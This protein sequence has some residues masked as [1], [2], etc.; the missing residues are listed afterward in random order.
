MGL[1]FLIHI[2]L[3][4]LSINPPCAKAEL[5]SQTENS[6]SAIFQTWGAWAPAFSPRPGAHILL[7]SPLDLAWGGRPSASSPALARGGSETRVRAW[8][9]CARRFYPGSIPAAAFPPPPQRPAR[10]KRESEK[11]ADTGPGFDA[12]LELAVLRLGHGL[13]GEPQL[14]EPPEAGQHHRAHL[15]GVPEAVRAVAAAALRRLLACLLLDHLLR[16]LRLLHAFLGHGARGRGAHG[17]RWLRRWRTG[18]PLPRVPPVE[19]GMLG[20]AMAAASA[21]AAAVHSLRRNPHKS[22]ALSVSP[23]PHPSFLSQ[24][25]LNSSS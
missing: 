19:C 18:A 14:V 8:R 6:R 12:D 4:L 21:S 5:S 9:G 25:S 23:P 15:L 7:P 20:C 11:G 17:L 1:R 3:I 10:K 2:F 22:G 24:R 13:P 16:L